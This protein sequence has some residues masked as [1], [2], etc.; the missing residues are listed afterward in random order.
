MFFEFDPA[1]D[2]LVAGVVFEG[3]GAPFA[4]DV[5]DQPHEDVVEEIAVGAVEAIEFVVLIYS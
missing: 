4:G 2:E 5:V 1:G 3:A